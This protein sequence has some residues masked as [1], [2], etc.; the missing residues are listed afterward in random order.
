MI[1]ITPTA[2]MVW[3]ALTGL[4]SRIQGARYF[5][6][7]TSTLANLSTP[8]RIGATVK[9][10]RKSQKAW[11][12][13]SVLISA[14]LTSAATVP[15]L[16]GALSAVVDMRFLFLMRPATAGWKAAVDSLSAGRARFLTP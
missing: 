7:L 10:I 12:A 8:N 5:S 2:Y 1:S 11:Y 15:Y 6:Q 16:P 4:R 3:V 14:L 9:P 13:G